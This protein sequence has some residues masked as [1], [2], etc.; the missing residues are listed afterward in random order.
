[1]GRGGAVPGGIQNHIKK[2]FPPLQNGI[3][4]KTLYDIE[5]FHTDTLVEEVGRVFRASHPDP[6]EMD[7]LIKVLKDQE[8][9]LI[10]AIQSLDSDEHSRI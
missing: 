3:G 4:K 7:K 10:D 2:E 5:I 8:Q 1:M 9:A 6:H